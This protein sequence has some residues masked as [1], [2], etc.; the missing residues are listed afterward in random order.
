MVGRLVG[1]AIAAG[2]I[3]LPAV[4]GPALVFD[5][6]DGR[7]LYAEDQ[8]SPWRPASLT[9]IMT[10][11]LVFEAI[12]AGKLTLENKIDYSEQANSQEPTKVGLPVGAQL[13]VETALQ[14]L[15]V[16]SANDVAV[17]LAEAVAGSHEAF[18]ARMN[19]T[20]ARLGM[21]RTR[22]ANANGLPAPEQVTTARDLARLAAAVARDFPEHARLWSLLGVSIGKRRLPS[23]NILLTRYPG[24]DG[25]KTGFICDSGYNVVATATRGDRK[26]IAVVLGETTIGGRFQRAADLLEHGFRKYEWTELFPAESLESLPLGEASAGPPSLRPVV[27]NEARPDAPKAD[28]KGK[29]ASQAHAAP[30]PWQP[31]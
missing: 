10:A 9:K 17:M 16:M 20:A 4:A 29:A 27:C 15:I 11:Y 8:D 14:T 25:M 6:A 28:K 13:S 3:A 26:L 22:F 2:A 31:W 24:T 12:K 30:K 7:I 19:R 23:H 21:S 5:A 18:V 1:A